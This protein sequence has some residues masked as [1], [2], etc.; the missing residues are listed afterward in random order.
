ML[1]RLRSDCGCEQAPAVTANLSDPL[2]SLVLNR[3]AKDTRHALERHRVAKAKLR[4]DGWH[5]WLA[6]Q[7]AAGSRDIFAWL[8]R[9]EPSWAPSPLSKQQQLDE[10]SAAWWSL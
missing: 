3:V 7:K 5:G 10:A 9:G 6:E 8:R 2:W 1:H 4:R